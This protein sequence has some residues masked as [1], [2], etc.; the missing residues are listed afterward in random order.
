MWSGIWSMAINRIAFWTWIWSTV[1]WGRKSLVYFNAGKT[2]LVLFDLS[3]KTGAIDI[4]LLRCWGWL[5]LPNWTGAHTLSLLLKL[6]A[7]KLEPWFVLWSLFLL[8]LL[9]ISINLPSAHTWKTVATSR[10][11]PLVASWNC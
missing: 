10:L 8:R 1:D 3:D 4:H 11:V 9:C 6:P 7:R 5:F 2:Q